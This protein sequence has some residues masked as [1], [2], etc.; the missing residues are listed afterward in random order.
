MKPPMNAK[1]APKRDLFAELSEG[2]T[3]LAQVR[4]GKRSGIVRGSENIYRDFDV[5]DADVRQLKAILAAEIIKTLDK[6][7][8]TVRKAQSLTG[9]DA[10]DF[11]RVRNADFRR[12]SVERF[13][14][15]INGLGSRVEV[16][17]TLRRAE[18]RHAAAVA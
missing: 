17:V 6:K 2:M 12:I 10:G 13:M 3:A 5:P 7:G 18:T 15:M 4:Q 11:S 16:A 8:L 14:A 9:I 1:R